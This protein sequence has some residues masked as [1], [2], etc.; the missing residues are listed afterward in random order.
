MAVHIVYENPAWLP[1]LTRALDA[2]GLRWEGHFVEGGILDLAQIPAEGVYL[3][4]MSPS[5]HTRGHQGG[6]ELV[7]EWLG[8]LE[9][10][11]RS[12]ING[13]R[14]FALEV[15]KVRQDIALRAAGIRTPETLAVV[16]G[17]LLAAARR[18]GTPF[19]TKHNQGGKGLGV[20]LFRD[21]DAFRAY[22]EG[23]D[24]VDS[25]DGVTLLQ[26]YIEPAE[27]FITRVEIVDGRFQYAIRSSTAG[28]FELC[29]ADACQAGGEACPADGG[30]TFALREDVTADDPL[31][32]A[33]VRFLARE[34]IDLAGIEFVE[35]A[36]GRRWTYDVN[37]TTN[38]NQAL[39][40]RHG[41]DG[42]AAVAAL[43]EARLAG[44]VQAA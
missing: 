41:L 27:P 28:G 38:F 11:G 39:E 42:W 44:R 40:A 30:D 19:V 35:D 9:A 31:V 8:L 15:S 43:A 32:R 17:D 7:R 4:R 18:L 29:P 5:A 34:G 13:S 33:Y 36:Q 25:P 23:P 37:G 10:H 26:R 24:F 14:A 1:P 3:N 12:V 2:R 22:V 6:V 20:Q 16:R 21:L